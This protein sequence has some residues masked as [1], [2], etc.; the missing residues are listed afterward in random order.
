MLQKYR[1]PD[2][3]RANEL[4]HSLQNF[5]FLT[6]NCVAQKSFHSNKS[7]SYSLAELIVL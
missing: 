7:G 5:E 1:Q 6:L 4:I 3:K 2:S